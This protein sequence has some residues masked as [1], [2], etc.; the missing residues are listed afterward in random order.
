MVVV[1]VV[2][3]TDLRVV[4]VARSSDWRDSAVSR[5]RATASMPFDLQILGHF[6][7]CLTLV[8]EYQNAF[9]VNRLRLIVAGMG[10]FMLGS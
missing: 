5:V 1:E 7:G 4:K 10:L 3:G 8:Y 2:G 6:L 9:D